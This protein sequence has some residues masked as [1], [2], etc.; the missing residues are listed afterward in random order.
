M[1]TNSKINLLNDLKPTKTTWKVEVQVINS[2]KKHS[3]YPEGDTYEFI[4]EDKI[5]CYIFLSIFASNFLFTTTKPSDDYLLFVIVGSEH[6]SK[7]WEVTNPHRVQKRW[8]H[9]N[10]L[11][12]D[13]EYCLWKGFS[14]GCWVM[15]QIPIAIHQVNRN[16]VFLT[17]LNLFTHKQNHREARI[18]EYIPI[19]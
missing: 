3:N 4:L 2:W 1:V 9:L 16:L 17:I 7:C 11:I 19:T 14:A 15:L 13:L 5:V 18:L 12:K 10:K 8:L 6:H